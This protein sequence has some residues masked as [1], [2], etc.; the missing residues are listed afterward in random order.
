MAN[1]QPTDAH[2]RIAH[3]ISEE[4]MM[5]SFTKRQRSILD[6][7]LRL[8][9]GCN[10]KEA[11][12][13]KMKYFELCGVPNSKIRAE[14]D[15]LVSA[16]VI[17]WEEAV[18]KFSFNK[19]YNEWKISIVKGYSKEILNE[20]VH[21]NL[22][23]S[24]E[25]SINNYVDNPV[26]NSVDN[27]IEI[28]NEVPILGT[29]LPKREQSS[30]L[31]RGIKLPKGEF[32]NLATQVISTD[33]DMSKES[34]K[35]SLYIDDDVEEQEQKKTLSKLST[36]YQKNIGVINSI[37]AEKLI[38]ISQEYSYELIEEAF[39]IAS[40]NHAKNIK[41]IEKI[42][43]SWKDKNIY[44]I[45]E[46]EAHEREKENSKNKNEI[47]AINSNVKPFQPKKKTGFHLANSRGDKYTADELEELVL[48]RSRA[49][50]E[51]SKIGD[52]SESVN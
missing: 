10:K 8:S 48:N 4:I 1:P 7:I 35:E 40:Y 14:L 5:Q 46:L 47:K 20:L 13:P 29:K 26:D 31:D 43:I 33:T 49:K 2:L 3:S 32:L 9:W 38:S 22:K 24:S 36:L 50:I 11:V 23:I 51:Q 30:H 41:Y 37:I 17:F 18:N 19:Y 12:I 25:N 34:I 45:E 16:K 15:Y 52:A 6:L 42:L 27:D 28:E 39:K 21:L 44:S